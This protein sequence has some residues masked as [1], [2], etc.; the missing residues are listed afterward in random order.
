MKRL[1]A[2]IVLVFSLSFISEAENNNK[3]KIGFIGSFSG[4]AQVYGEAAKNGFELALQEIGENSFSVYYEDDQFQPAKTVTAFKKLVD[5]E[6]VDLV[7]SV[8]SSPSSAIAP[9][10]QQKK[11]PLIAW[12]SDRRVS[13]GRTYVIR[14]YPSGFAEGERVAQEAIKLGY[15]NVAVIISNNDYAQSWRSGLVANLD[16]KAVLLDEELSGELSD[17]KPIILKAKQR[18]VKQYL[19]CLNPGKSGLIAK[20]IQQLGSKPEIGGCEYLHDKQEV[21]AA[22]GALDN[23]WF[24]TI[25][26]EEKFREKYVNRYGNESVLS[27]GANLHDTAVLVH[28]ATSVQSS[29]SLI[30]K[31]LTPRTIDGAVGRFNVVSNKE[32]RFFDIPLVIKKAKI[33]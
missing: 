24:A 6:K 25:P 29:N 5:V 11:V 16:T 21:I 30:E 8:G 18:G 4:A 19:I 15:S 9:L 33:N 1:C 26:I 3:L 13:A 17:F 20:H 27:G 32:D 28:Q 22:A 23:A 12:A 2:V 10:A 7:I 31:L 14:S